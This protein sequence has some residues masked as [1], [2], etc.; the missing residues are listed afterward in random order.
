MEN[1]AKPLE[2]FLTEFLA[3]FSPLQCKIVLNGTNKKE[4]DK[5][6]NFPLTVLLF[7][8]KI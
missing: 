7:F 5:I 6:L 3:I 4:N 2:N 8:K 1:R